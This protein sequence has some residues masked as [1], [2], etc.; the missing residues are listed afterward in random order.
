M[1]RKVILLAVLACAAV[2]LALALRPV[3]DDAIAD[4][5][6]ADG[7]VPPAVDAATG[8][9][10][11]VS[12]TR[13]A[14]RPLPP[15]DA[16]L[17]Q[18]I[19]DLQAQADAGNRRAACRLGMELLRCQQLQVWFDI[20]SGGDDHEARYEAEGN[21]AIANFFAEEKLWQ[22]E[23][24]AQCGNVPETLRNE[25]ARYLRQAALAGDPSA[26]LTYAL[27]Q[28]WPPDAR[29]V[30]VG[31]PFDAWRREAP[32]MIHAVLR[33]GH[34]GAVFQ[35][36]HA[37]GGDNGPLEAMIP[38]DP[39][40]SFVHHLLAIQLFGHRERDSLTG[41]LGP[42]QVAMARREAQMLHQRYFKGR[43]FSSE[44]VV[45]NAPFLYP[46]NLDGPRPFCEDPV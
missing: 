23:R 40:Q 4:E 8:P 33:S 21:L 17:A 36:A 16:P 10:S 19:P 32:R 3:R 44:H 29:G 11:A 24:L 34:P 2:L 9:T 1:S 45:P 6:S 43:R 7:D 39:Y 27:G 37:Y 15:P 14:E 41:Q 38:D 12:A 35:L 30:A 18:V 26:M 22:I 20:T 13:P 25:G 42:E 31:A 5:R 46:S 28:H